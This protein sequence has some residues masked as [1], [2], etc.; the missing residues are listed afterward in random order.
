MVEH[1]DVTTPRRPGRPRKG[2]EDRRSRIEDAARAEFLEAGYAGA[3]IRAIARRAE[4]DPALVR[5]Y[6]TDKAELFAAA[7]S[8][9]VRPDVI[10]GSVIDGPIEGLGERLVGRLLEAW[11]TPEI[12]ERAIPLF[13]SA[14]GQDGAAR[15]L[16]EFIVGELIGRIEDRLDAIGDSSAAER[17]GL[18]A[19]QMVG[20]I[21]ARY[22][23]RLEPIASLPPE[24][25]VTLVGP[26][27]QG[28]LTGPL[29][30]R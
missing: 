21:A 10:L 7:V 3:S 22:L 28:Y 17:A 5:H 14:I 30:D 1:T 6:F 19:S 8:L 25:I 13:R 4:V 27:L 15:S 23:V 16:P 18:V 12:R 2:R 29:G 26:V 9:P 20:L 11:D 24:R